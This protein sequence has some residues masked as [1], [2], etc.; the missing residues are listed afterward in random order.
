MSVFIASIT[1]MSQNFFNSNP[2]KFDKYFAITPDYQKYCL[3]AKLPTRFTITLA[4]EAMLI[5]DIAIHLLIGGVKLTTGAVKGI[6]AVASGILGIETDHQTPSK[7]AAVHIGFACVYAADI[8]AS[9]ASINKTYPQHLIDKIKNIFAEFLEVPNKG[10]TVAY[11]ANLEE[12][13]RVTQEELKIRDA[14]LDQLQQDIERTA[15]NLK[16]PSQC[17]LIVNEILNPDK[18]I[19]LAKARKITE[20]NRE[21]LETTHTAKPKVTSWFESENGI[22]GI[23]NSLTPNEKRTLAPYEHQNYLYM[24]PD[25]LLEESLIQE[26][27]IE[28]TLRNNPSEGQALKEEKRSIENSLSENELVI[29][30]REE[31]TSVT[32]RP[33]EETSSHNTPF[34]PQISARS[35][36][37]AYDKR[38]R[39]NLRKESQLANS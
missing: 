29:P 16:E 39:K 2:L 22:N 10:V 36:R 7:Q 9:I 5:H 21:Q 14:D 4:K 32:R 26:E 12:Q 35:R 24:D 13:L 11:D 30:E 1:E 34:L 18:S 33:K 17:E 38:M 31:I 27:T 20:N 8:L 15:Q 23:I 3:N 37:L 28:E 19:I 6:C 25:Y